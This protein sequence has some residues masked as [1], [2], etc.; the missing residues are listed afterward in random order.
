LAQ[1]TAFDNRRIQ[2]GQLSSPFAT[3]ILPFTTPT[4]GDQV[5]RNKLCRQAPEQSEATR[6]IRV[7]D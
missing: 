6:K 2:A 5:A 1:S 3:V 7:V 4:A